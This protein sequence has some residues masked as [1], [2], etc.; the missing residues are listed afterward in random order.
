[1]DRRLCR[2]PISPAC[3]RASIMPAKHVMRPR[4]PSNCMSTGCTSWPIRSAVG[5]KRSSLLKPGLLKT[6]AAAPSLHALIRAEQHDGA[7]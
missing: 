5:Q 3:R 1:M 7:G 2:Y 4:P 6:G